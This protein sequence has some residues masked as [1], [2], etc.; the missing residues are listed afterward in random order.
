M[1]DIIILNDG[2]PIYTT[3]FSEQPKIN[4]FGLVDGFKYGG[5][6]YKYFDIEYYIRP[7]NFNGLTIMNP[8]MNG[9]YKEELFF[10]YLYYI[11]NPSSNVYTAETLLKEGYLSTSKFSQYEAAEGEIVSIK[12]V[13]FSKHNFYYEEMELKFNVQKD[14]SGKIKRYAQNG[15]PDFPQTAQDGLISKTVITTTDLSSS[16]T[17]KFYFKNFGT[18]QQHWNLLE[19][20]K[21][22]FDKVMTL[23]CFKIYWITLDTFPLI[24]NNLYVD[25]LG[26]GTITETNPNVTELIK[27]L[28][29]IKKS[30]CYYQDVTP[31]FDIVDPKIEEYSTYYR[32]LVAFSEEIDRIRYDLQ[33]K[34]E[35]EK[36]LLISQLL[37]GDALKIL[38]LSTRKFLIKKYAK[39]KN[40]LDSDEEQVLK[41]INTIDISNQNEVNDFLGWLIDDK[42]RTETGSQ[43]PPYYETIYSLLYKKID[44]YPDILKVVEVFGDKSFSKDNKTRFVNAILSLWTESKYNP[45]KNLVNGQPDFS[46]I[47]NSTYVYDKT[48]K[49]S[50]IINYI[51][52][53]KYGIYND[54]FTFA[55]DPWGHGIYFIRDNNYHLEASSISNH[56]YQP[57]TL[58]H[59][60]S[61]SDTAIQLPYKDG[62]FNGTVP[63]FFLKYVDDYGDDQDLF[64][65][66]GYFVDIVTIATGIGALAKLRH[67]RYLSRLGQILLIIETVQLGADI[68]KFLLNFVCSDSNEFCKKI[69]TILTFLELASIVEDPIVIAKI[70]KTAKLIVEQA[71]NDGWPSDF[72]IPIN[73]E[74]P[75]QKIEELAG[76]NDSQFFNEY[77]EKARTILQAKIEAD[78]KNFEKYYSDNQMLELFTVAS[79][80]GLSS[81]DIAG[82]VHQACRKRDPIYIATVNELK[83]RIDNLIEVK[84]RGYPYPFINK[85]SFGNYLENKI[86][87]FI[88]MFN[89]PNNN[90]KYG[91][92]G[93]TSQTSFSPDV[94]DT[95]W[96]IFLENKDEEREF[97]KDLENRYNKYIEEGLMAGAKARKKIKR[98]LERYAVKPQILKE[99]VTAVYDGKVVDLRSLKEDG[100]GFIENYFGATP[101][102]ISLKIK[103]ENEPIPSIKIKLF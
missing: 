102:D 40:L 8:L 93:I 36:L 4:I 73:G 61:E 72:T 97:L 33:N 37:S 87:P 59:Y 55:F 85:E 89:F 79:N 34:S 16:P 88:S 41:L 84:R 14:G 24:T 52:E 70:R 42:E 60:P 25:Q 13:D 9:Y 67:L 26:N 5:E 47:D 62:E 23:I 58:V 77:N 48:Y 30:W 44:N 71:L 64:T 38:P 11:N 46:L 86:K 35:N 76:I 39:Q 81:T 29:Q 15:N 100:S 66:I 99:Y 3:A 19:S 63:L 22:K 18:P 90:I 20:S 91:G 56:F 1:S 96:W 53:K 51:S 50:V 75:K 101:S 6:K 65:K 57:V 49:H 103:G 10:K 31:F 82:I 32:S 45:Y 94:Q 7:I 17:G 27:A 98:M 80:K 83:Q 12:A 69:K 43:L 68:I 54:D 95:D 92:S 21:E 28:A 74:T 78:P 2:M